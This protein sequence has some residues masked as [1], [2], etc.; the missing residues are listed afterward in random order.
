MV[1]LPN[2]KSKWNLVH[3]R[4][5]AATNFYQNQLSNL[6]L[7]FGLVGDSFTDDD[8]ENSQ[9]KWQ[10]YWI[11]LIFS[12]FT[13]L[14]GSHNWFL[15]LQFLELRLI[16]NDPEKYNTSIMICSMNHRRKR[17]WCLTHWID[18]FFPFPTALISYYIQIYSWPR[19]FK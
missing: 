18:Y 10:F 17:Q 13:K 8:V 6:A 9:N 7:V 14:N 11:S 4:V 16:L 3:L 15:S 19:A 2:G 1:T 5:N 12:N